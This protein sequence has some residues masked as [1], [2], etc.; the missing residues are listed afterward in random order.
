MSVTLTCWIRSAAS[1]GLASM[2][3]AALT[4]C[5]AGGDASGTGNAVPTS[6]SLSAPP[7]AGSGARVVLRFGN[8][9][10]AATL[11]DTSQA[12]H[13]A[14]MLPLAVRLKDVWGQTK[15]GR[16]PRQ[17]AVDGATPIHNPTQGGIYF[18][19]QSEV[20]AVYYDDLGQ[21]VPAPGLVRL[22]VVD[23]GLDCLAEAGDEF[24]V[25]IELAAVTEP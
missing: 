19:P 16:L 22:G 8:R 13:L 15:S 9:V 24:T 11:A 21:T 23:T 4:G 1:A 7:G 10:A 5:S 2:L 6:S 25:R 3:V 17:L 18:W 20:I 12:Q 14:E